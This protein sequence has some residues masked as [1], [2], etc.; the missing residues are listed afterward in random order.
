MTDTQM[1]DFTPALRAMLAEAIGPDGIDDLDL[2]GKLI[3]EDLLWPVTIEAASAAQAAGLVKPYPNADHHGIYGRKYWDRF[4]A[5]GLSALKDFEVQPALSHLHCLLTATFQQ[6]LRDPEGKAR[7]A[8]PT[9]D[10]MVAAMVTDGVE[11]VGTVTAQHI[12][13]IAA[14]LNRMLQHPYTRRPDRPVREHHSANDGSWVY[15]M[16]DGWEPHVATWSHETGLVPTPS[17][18]PEPPVRHYQIETQGRLVM[19]S[20]SD[21]DEDL[22]Q[23]FHEAKHTKGW[24][25]IGSDQGLNQFVLNVYEATGLISIKLGDNFPRIYRDGDVLRGMPSFDEDL[26]EGIDCLVDYSIDSPVIGAWEDLAAFVGGDDKLEALVADGSVQVFDVPAGPL[27]IYAPDG[28]RVSGF[29]KL[30]RKG[31]VPGLQVI[32]NE[33]TYFVISPTEIEFA[34]GMTCK[35]D[36]PE[37]PTPETASGPA[38]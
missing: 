35:V 13:A 28:W 7:A 3:D 23:N 30:F 24:T 17:V 15:V 38:L 29:S 12:D 8:N 34:D 10:T 20:P 33:P 19:F 21:T 31:D 36:M 5:K 9:L 27:N 32:P 6:W 14:D 16:F 18:V 22:Q 26:P 4:S 1:P 11:K 37:R 2:Y 25:R